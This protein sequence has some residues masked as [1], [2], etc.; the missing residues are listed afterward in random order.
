MTDYVAYYRV[1]TDQQGRS[2]LG[3][4]AQRAAV[5]SF[6]RPSDRL[7]GEHTEVESG[8]AVRRPQLDAAVALCRRRRATLLVAKLDRL[9]RRVSL[10]SSLM[11][12]DVPFVAAD[13]PE[14]NRL[15]IHVL[16]AVAEHERSM[17]SQRTKDALA[18]AKARGTRLGGDRGWRPAP[19][20]SA[21]A[22]A[23]LAEAATRHAWLVLP[24]IERLRD[25]GRATLASLAEGLDEAGVATP[26][27]GRWTPTAVRRALLRL[28]RWQPRA[29][30]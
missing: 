9:A 24:E 7:V 17:I 2:G 11:E 29:A 12:S 20:D 14:A 26:R 25:E 19:D 28:G 13:M 23:A 18:A 15:T 4:E 21:A 16:A 6:L 3:L 27:G 5:S 22:R 30:A 1:S 8:G 10:I